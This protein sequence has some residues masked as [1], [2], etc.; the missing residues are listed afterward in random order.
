MSAA[1][2]VE[3]VASGPRS[4]QPSTVRRHLVVGASVAA[5]AALVA[6]H[7]PH[8][9]GA[10]GFC[11]FHALTGLWCPACGGLRATNDLAHLRL[12]AAWSENALWVVAAPAVVVGWLVV[13]ARRAR[14][15]PPRPVP[16]WAQV[17]GL[18]LVVVFGVLRNLPA[19]AWLA[20]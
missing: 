1:P 17:A 6:L 15:L 8:T 9:P 12:G 18:T 2:V 14:G 3:P 20:P 19:F 5:A 7:D 4:R 11:P 10:Y 13:L 16:A